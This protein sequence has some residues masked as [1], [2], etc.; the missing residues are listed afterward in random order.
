MD[1]KHY[2]GAVKTL[3]GYYA[4]KL[5]DYFAWFYRWIFFF[6]MDFSFFFLDIF[7]VSSKLH[8]S[9]KS[10]SWFSCT[11]TLVLGKCGV[12]PSCLSSFCHTTLSNLCW[13]CEKTCFFTKTCFVTPI[14]RY[15]RNS[16]FP[17]FAKKRLKIFPCGAVSDFL[18]NFWFNTSKTCFLRN[19]ISKKWCFLRKKSFLFTVKLHVLHQISQISQNLSHFGL[20]MTYKNPIFG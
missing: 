17:D 6:W 4:V 9:F 19:K 15:W 18:L 14:D 11:Y 13:I 20:K 2:F 5:A 8:L 12:N 7:R 10:I 1:M 16:F 3:L